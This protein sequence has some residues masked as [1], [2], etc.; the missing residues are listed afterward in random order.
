MLVP[1]LAP[2]VS[3]T[4][5]RPSALKSKRQLLTGLAGLV[6]L[7]SRPCRSAQKFPD[8]VEVDV[9]LGAVQLKVL[10]ASL[11]WQETLI[12]QAVE[13]ED[14]GAVE[15]DP[16]GMAVWPAAQVLAHAAVAYGL[17][18]RENSKERP[19]LDP[20]TTKK[21]NDFR[22]FHQFLV[23]VGLQSGAEGLGIGRWVWSSRLAREETC[24]KRAESS[25]RSRTLHEKTMET[26]HSR[27]F[28]LVLRRCQ[29]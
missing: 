1:R 5:P 3:P 29:P 13:Q 25:R 10:E 4:A 12:E 27:R 19:V 9:D 24:P 14:E 26:A 2:R 6:A 28:C 11:D 22:P 18:A 17:R 15:A 21:T 16:Y 8:A 7:P 23:L 20:K